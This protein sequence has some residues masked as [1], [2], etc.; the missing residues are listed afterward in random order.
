MRWSKMFQDSMGDDAG[1]VSVEITKRDGLRMWLRWGN[2]SLHTQTAKA[3]DVS[4]ALSFQR[5]ADDD[6]TAHAGLWPVVTY[7][8]IEHPWARW[9][10]KRLAGN[11]SREIRAWFGP[12]D[13]TDYVSAHWTLWLDPNEWRSTTPRWRSGGWYPAQT[14]FGPITYSET[15][16]AKQYADPVRILMPEGEYLATVNHTVSTW[17][18][19]RWPGKWLEM[20]STTVEVDGGIPIPGK[21]ENGW[22]CDEDAV[23]KSSIRGHSASEAVRRFVL[24]VHR[25]RMERG[26]TDWKPRP[27]TSPASTDPAPQSAIEGSGR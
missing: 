5:H 12:D 11:E 4:V 8:G 16:A 23:Y 6:I 3:R 2:L 26:G 14:L 20:R 13:S 17:T 15:P 1:S 27:H 21:G 9:L 19:P 24:D 22:D 25:T 18:R 10:A 7:V